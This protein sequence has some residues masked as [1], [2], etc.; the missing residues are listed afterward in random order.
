MNGR[1][2]K[3]ADLLAD[4]RQQGFRP[5]GPVFVFLDTDRPRP[6][7]YADMPLTVEICIRP[8]DQIESLELWPLVGLNVAV[9]GGSTVTDRL[10][11]L[12]RAIVAAGPEFVAGACPAEHC[13]FAWSKQ[14]GWQ[15]DRVPNDE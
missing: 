2:P 8:A 1:F 15:F 14:S 3:G 9:H 10:R 6:A 12:L 5:S 7:L 11:Q 4:I 13:L